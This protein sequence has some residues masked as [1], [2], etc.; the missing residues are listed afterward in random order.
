MFWEFKTFKTLWV[1]LGK[2]SYSLLNNRNT[3][4]SA[5][6]YEKQ[7]LKCRATSH[8]WYPHPYCWIAN[9]CISC[10]VDIKKLQKQGCNVTN[11]SGSIL[12]VLWLTWQ[13]VHF[14][15]KREQTKHKGQVSL[16]MSCGEGWVIW[17]VKPPECFHCS[18]WFPW[19][20]GLLSAQGGPG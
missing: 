6:Y 9:T 2:T 8:T 18:R 7:P 16:E 14:P 1:Q 10:I 19:P 4:M 13:E 11:I 15:L 17:P 12:F 20:L 5:T 3:N